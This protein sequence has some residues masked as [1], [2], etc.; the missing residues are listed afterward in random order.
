M[1]TTHGERGSAA[2]R[3]VR[4]SAI[5]DLLAVADRPDVISLAGGLPAPELLPTRRV[6]EAA[7]RA[8]TAP[9]VLQY[10]L[11]TGAPALRDVVHARESEAIGR[12][13]GA[14]VI[15]HGSQQALAL[16]AQALLDPG[17]TVVVEDPG[18]TGAL[19][20]F[21]AVRANIE[22]VPMD[23]EGMR[24]DL[25]RPIVERGGVRVVH[26][27]SNFHNPGG[28]T[29]AAE[30]R[31]ELARLADEFGFWIVEDD[32]Y[33]RLRFRGR[34]VE[35]VAAHSDRV[36]RLSSASKIVA[37]ALRVG[38]MHGDA[39][40]LAL[41]EKLKQGADLCGS[42]LTQAIAAEILADGPWSDAHIGRIRSLYGERASAL[43]AA[44]KRAYGDRLALT[45]PAGGMFLWGEFADGTDT[46]AALPR[47]VDAGVAYVPGSAFAVASSHTGALRF[48]FTTAEPARLREAVERLEKVF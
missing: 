28:A 8:L 2:V 22:A 43:H 6:A 17:D 34:A 38:W 44:L 32:P 18:Y 5:R 39:E 27:V 30:R 4:G 9:S 16:L 12:D 1:T 31:I 21:A 23:A 19:Q 35:P 7:E 10:G 29:L 41:V 40:V 25:L 33:G 11:T 45:E 37:P 46:A 47:A 15:T 14:V 42:T 24:V 48:C 26:T 20:V 13:A 36:I 3:A